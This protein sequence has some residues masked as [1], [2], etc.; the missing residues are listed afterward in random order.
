MNRYT[1]FLFAALGTVVAQA[2]TVVQFD[3]FPTGDFTSGTNNGFTINANLGYL[4]G[5]TFGF[6]GTSAGVP[7]PL[8]LSTYTFTDGGSFNFLSIDIDNP[9]ITG[10]KL[11]AVIVDGYLGATLVAE[12]TF[13]VPNIG[14]TPA[15]FLA[16]NLAGLNIDSLVVSVT[17]SSSFSPLIDNVTFATSAPEPATMAMLGIGVCALWGFKQ[18]RRRLS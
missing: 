1:F 16:L 2:G 4:W 5:N 13:T 9:D 18:L 7:F 10:G 17:S 11:P 12:D 6:P 8:T 14:Q 3:G 15:T